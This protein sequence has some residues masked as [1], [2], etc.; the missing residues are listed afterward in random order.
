MSEEDSSSPLPGG[1]RVTLNDF[2]LD[3]RKDNDYLN[4][5]VNDNGLSIEGGTSPDKRLFLTSLILSTRAEVFV[6]I[7]FNSGIM[8]AAASRA[9]SLT[10]GRYIGFELKKELE[11][12]S[13]HLKNDFGYNIEMHWGDSASTVPEFVRAYPNVKADII[14]IDGNHSPEG[15]RSD[16][17]NCLRLISRGGLILVDDTKDLTLKPIVEKELGS[18]NVVH[19]KGLSENDTGLTLYRHL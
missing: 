13:N 19:F 8:A 11:L 18:N 2:L 16:I 17:R 15:L 1:G 3:F 10:G 5:F 9:L 4:K 7:G 14:F 12:V 6:E